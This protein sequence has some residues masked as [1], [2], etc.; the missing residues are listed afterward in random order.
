MK[1]FANLPTFQ[2]LL[3]DCDD[4]VSL[5]EE[6]FSVTDV[7]AIQCG[8]E[9]LQEHVNARHPFCPDFVTKPPI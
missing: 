4:C 1:Y 3:R 5:Y 2:D 8:R 6:T 7:R 9:R